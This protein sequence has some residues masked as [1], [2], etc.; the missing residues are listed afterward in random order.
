MSGYRGND[1]RT[2]MAWQHRDINIAE[3]GGHAHAGHHHRQR[4]QTP[5]ARHGGYP[6]PARHSVDRE[7]RDTRSTRS[8]S[9]G[10]SRERQ[11]R[12][13]SSERG[14]G[15]YRSGAS[16]SST[17]NTGTEDT[18]ETDSH[19]VDTV[20]R[21][22]ESSR[23]MQWVDIII[24]IP[25]FTTAVLWWW[26]QSQIFCWSSQLLVTVSDMNIVIIIDSVYSQ[27]TVVQ[28]CVQVYSIPGAVSV[29]PSPAGNQ[30]TR[31]TETLPLESCHAELSSHS[32][33]THT[34]QLDNDLLLHPDLDLVTTLEELLNNLH[35]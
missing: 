14:R 8:R 5:P 25:V 13:Y 23:H 7:T 18:T 26:L 33:T 12:G 9:R 1:H 30:V 22:N 34:Y 31:L 3:Q 11:T 20:D 21:D 29:L 27:C 4:E 2:P 6:S 32:P 35:I 19:T 16:P 10:Q 28:C 24:I 15:Q 17:D